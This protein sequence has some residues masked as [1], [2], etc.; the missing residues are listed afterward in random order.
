VIAD[1]GE[2]AQELLGGCELGDA[3]RTKRLVD[4]ASRL[5]R[6]AGASMAKSCD[7]DGAAQ[8]ASYRFLRN[9]AI[10]AEAIGE[11]GFAAVARQAGAAQRVLALEDT[12][13]LSFR[14][15]L[16]ERLGPVGSEVGAKTHGYLV[17]SVLLVAGESERT[18]GLIEQRW[19]SRDPARHGQ[20]HARKRRAYAEKESVKWQRASER[21]A[22][23][24]GA[25][26]AQVVSVCDREADLYEYL[27][28]KREHGQR[29]VL[30][31]KVDRPL[32]GEE[33]RLFSALQEQ[34]VLIAHKEVHIAQRGARKARTARLELR[35]GA[36]ELC[37]PVQGGAKRPRVAVHAVLA[38][39]VDAPEGVK[40]LCWRLVTSEPI[41]S[42]DAVKQV[43]RDYELRWRIEEF[44][45]AWKS[46]VGVER[47]R[48]QSASNLERMMVITAFIAVRLLQL[49][50]AAQAPAAGD[51]PLEESLL[52]PEEW[53]VLWRS[54]ER[55]ASPSKPPSA[56]WAYRAL[57]KLGGFTDTK[58][59]GRPGWATLWDGWFRLQE[60]LEG[61]RLAQQMETEM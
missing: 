30:R 17:H 44:H 50:E 38:R 51:T 58:G 45:K 43:V 28:Y 33:K 41:D 27:R 56:Q 25:Q 55:R 39:E 57:A 47:Q 46:G 37:A 20:K 2:W 6:H 35:A 4:M 36:V 13:T 22:E 10:G 61:Y 29:F 16:A 15:A 60:R 8:L 34:A 48:L 19:W 3:R 24:L 9:E 12:T 52:G 40:P 49:R 59:T 11:G 53:R 23:R 54:T 7:G 21:M 31:A 5:A 1:E 14:H 32:N 26:M 42:A 18:L